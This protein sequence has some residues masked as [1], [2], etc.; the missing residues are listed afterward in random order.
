MSSAMNKVALNNIFCKDSIIKNR[1]RNLKDLIQPVGA[2]QGME[3]QGKR[4]MNHNH[5]G[6]LYAGK[7]I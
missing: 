2:W 7:A 4:S 6:Y 3:G 1:D 5:H